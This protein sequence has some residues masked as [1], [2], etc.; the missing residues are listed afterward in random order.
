LLELSSS[1]AVNSLSSFT[2]PNDGA[3]TEGRPPLSSLLSWALVAFTIEVDNAFEES[4]PHRTTASRKARL[5]PRGPWLVSSAMW[6]S[7]MQFVPA[8]GIALTDLEHVT[9]GGCA[10]SGTN[11]GM[12]RWGYVTL[13]ESRRVRATQAGARAQ[14]VWARLPNAVESRWRE[15]HG[16]TSI[17]ALR[18]ALV[19]FVDRIDVDLPDFVPKNAAHG[20]RLTIE[21]R[22]RVRTDFAERDLPVLLSKALL[23][24]TL[25]YKRAGKLSLSHAANPL[26]P[27]A[28]GPVAV[29]DLPR[30]TGVAKETLASMTRW[31]AGRGLVEPVDV[32]A[33]K[34]LRLTDA[35]RQ[36]L[37][38]SAHADD[39]SLRA[40]I[41]PLVPATSTSRR[42]RSRPLSRF[43][44][45]GA[46]RPALPRRCPTIPSSRIAAAIP[47]AAEPTQN[48]GG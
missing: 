29:R 14:E 40:A 4:M 5:P 15:R 20:G 10:L 36:A 16:E 17:I 7:C 11:P 45:A 42:R 25:D 32:G 44:R 8:D 46:P 34:G 48:R 37:E 35:G 28:A 22:P 27:L 30:R 47:T 43:R 18:A 13:D 6:Y 38:A 33:V 2:S 1:L 24:L 9:F 12:V 31:L 26:R 41:E 3:V 19:A 23:A 39:P 21:A